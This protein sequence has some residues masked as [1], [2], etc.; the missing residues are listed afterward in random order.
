MVLV[1]ERNGAHSRYGMLTEKGFPADYGD[2]WMV[3]AGEFSSAIKI[4]PKHQRQT[5]FP[6]L[7]LGW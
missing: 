7:S 3:Q 5:F 1:T 6:L 4:S 2:I